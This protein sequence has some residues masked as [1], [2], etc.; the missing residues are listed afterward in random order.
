MK[1]IYFEPETKVTEMNLNVVILQ[2]T[3]EV[4]DDDDQEIGGDDG[5]GSNNRNTGRDV[6]WGNLW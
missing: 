2:G 1:K 6:T 5:F 4:S 3:G